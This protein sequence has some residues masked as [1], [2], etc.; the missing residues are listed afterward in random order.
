MNFQNG[1]AIAKIDENA[2]ALYLVIVKPCPTLEELSDYFK[3]KAG[4]DWAIDKYNA[5]KKAT[6]PKKLKCEQ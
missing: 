6:E 5:H 3:A 2:N 1:I 4:V